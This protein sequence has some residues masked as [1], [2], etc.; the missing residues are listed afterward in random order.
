MVKEIAGEGTKNHEAAGRIDLLLDV[1]GRERVDYAGLR[2][3]PGEPV[4]VRVY[5]TR[6]AHPLTNT[7]SR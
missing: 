4:S 2:F 5:A 1:M 7:P 6:A 3:V